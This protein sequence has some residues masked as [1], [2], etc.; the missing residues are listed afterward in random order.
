LTT[1]TPRKKQAV[2]SAATSRVG[3]RASG[4]CLCGLA[5]AAGANIAGRRLLLLLSDSSFE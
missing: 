1:Q 4:A 3:T 2:Q 5:A